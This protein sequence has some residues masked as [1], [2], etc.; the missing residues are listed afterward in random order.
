M[1]EEHRWMVYESEMPW[2]IPQPKRK[3]ATMG[4]KKIT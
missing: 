4:L 1:R 3:E 2:K